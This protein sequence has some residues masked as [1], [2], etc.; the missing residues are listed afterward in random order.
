MVV[1]Y[2]LSILTTRSFEGIISVSQYFGVI[3][4]E[5]PTP[6]LDFSENER[7]P[8]D[9]MNQGKS[10]LPQTQSSEAKRPSLMD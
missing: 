4:R 9:Y 7:I 10:C 1:Y 6:R 3:S 5:S 8:S 2:S